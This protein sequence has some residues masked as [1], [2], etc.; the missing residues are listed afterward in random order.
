MY[1]LPHFILS[2][3]VSQSVEIADK[4]A[5]RRPAAYQ[6]SNSEAALSRTLVGYHH[7]LLHPDRASGDFVRAPEPGESEEEQIAVG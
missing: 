7:L 5:D 4:V 1:V 6:I 2:R 3:H